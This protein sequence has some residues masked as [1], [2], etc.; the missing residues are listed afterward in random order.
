MFTRC[1]ETF[2]SL[3]RSTNFFN[4][5]ISLSQHSY[6]M[7]CKVPGGLMCLGNSSMR[8]LCTS[9]CTRVTYSFGGLVIIDITNVI[10]CCPLGVVG[11]SFMFLFAAPCGIVFI[12]RLTKLKVHVNYFHTRY[13]NHLHLLVGPQIHFH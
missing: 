4:F 7:I 3:S 11:F 1:W 10:D 13:N 2:G 6:Q 5:C 8:S 12:L 9:S